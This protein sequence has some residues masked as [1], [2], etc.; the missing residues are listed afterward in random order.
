MCLIHEEGAHIPSNIHGLV[1]AAF[2]RGQI[3]A[4]FALLA[5]ELRTFYKLPA[6]GQALAAA[7]PPERSGPA[8][9]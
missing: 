3:G 7:A 9:A 8:I 6:I 2:T 5:R 1:Y 4:A